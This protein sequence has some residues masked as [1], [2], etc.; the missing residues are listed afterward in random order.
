M[1]ADDAGESHGCKVTEVEDG[2]APTSW[3]PREGA[4][5]RAPEVEQGTTLD[6]WF[7]E[8]SAR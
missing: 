5:T 7:Q 1:V 2:A 6:D 4:W 3:S 8:A